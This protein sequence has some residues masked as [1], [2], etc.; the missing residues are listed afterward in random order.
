LAEVVKLE[1]RGADGG[2][3]AGVG[4]GARGDGEFAGAENEVAV[5]CCSRGAL[6][7]GL[8]ISMCG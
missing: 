8:N 1:T 7:T 3:D 2:Q 6:D 5:S 4:D